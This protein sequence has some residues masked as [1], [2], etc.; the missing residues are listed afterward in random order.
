MGAC[1][2]LVSVRISAARGKF[3]N[4]SL[5]KT[6]AAGETF[7]SV[8]IGLHHRVCMAV[9]IASLTSCLVVVLLVGGFRLMSVQM[10]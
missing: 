9:L 6:R 5:L 7:P 4:M 1:L 10:I 2:F 3:K 8:E